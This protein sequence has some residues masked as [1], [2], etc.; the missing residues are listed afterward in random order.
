MENIVQLFENEEFGLVRVVM[1]DGVPWL[2]GKDVATALGYK[3]T[4]QA[5]RNHVDDE[6]KLTRQINGSGQRRNM[7]V[8]NESGFYSLVFSSEL[9][10]AKTFKHWVTS[11]VLP[12]IRKTGGY[13]VD[14]DQTAK[15]NIRWERLNLQRGIELRKT[16]K[17]VKDPNVKQAL[18]VEAANLIAGKEILAES[19][20]YEPEIIY[21][22]KTR[23]R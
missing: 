9:D 23:G 20:F 16:A 17:T 2:V 13:S 6:D 10:G 3:D 21:K 15:T 5:L 19:P 11:E 7:T 4:D 12:A 1:I 14:G 22:P 8:I 18:L